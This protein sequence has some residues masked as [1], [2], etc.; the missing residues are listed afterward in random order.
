MRH[1]NIYTRPSPP[2]P[3][4]GRRVIPLSPRR[5]GTSAE[6]GTDDNCANTCHL[7][8]TERPSNNIRYC[9]V[10]STLCCRYC[11]SISRYRGCEQRESCIM[12]L[13]SHGVY[14]TVERVF[15]GS[16]VLYYMLWALAVDSISSRIIHTCTRI[17]YMHTNLPH[18]NNNIVCNIHRRKPVNLFSGGGVGGKLTNLKG[19]TYV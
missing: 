13:N 5:R 9:L 18:A 1:N 10:I 3:P 4:L 6:N 15:T 14:P 17:M 2:L 16:Y 7:I 12:E 8:V 11:K 19:K